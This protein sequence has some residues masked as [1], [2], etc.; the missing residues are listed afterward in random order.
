[1]SSG[2]PLRGEQPVSFVLILYYRGGLLPVI[3]SCGAGRSS[4]VGRDGPPAPAFRPPPRSPHPKS[5]SAVCPSQDLA[6]QHPRQTSDPCPSQ[7]PDPQ[8]GNHCGQALADVNPGTRQGPGVLRE[9]SWV[10]V[11]APQTAGQGSFGGGFVRAGGHRDSGL[12]P[13]YPPPRGPPALISPMWSRVW[14]SQGQTGSHPSC[15]WEW[16]HI[17]RVDVSP[18]PFLQVSGP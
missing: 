2:C 1:M 12:P 4:P 15:P 18:C 10:T 5:W 8:G 14:P 3:S 6:A 13:A 17:N 7:F 9:A 11:T 16:A